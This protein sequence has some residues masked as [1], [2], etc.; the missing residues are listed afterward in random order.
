MYKYDTIII[1]GGLSGLS[2][3]VELSALGRKYF[4]AGTTSILRWAY[5]FFY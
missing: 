5:T 2:A 1:G 3:A 4:I